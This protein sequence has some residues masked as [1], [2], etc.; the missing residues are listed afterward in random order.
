MG[1]TAAAFGGV[2]AAV[3]G[4]AAAV[5]G[6][7]HGVFVGQVLPKGGHTKFQKI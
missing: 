6:G 5:V 3:E 1:P 2:A 4:E 7:A